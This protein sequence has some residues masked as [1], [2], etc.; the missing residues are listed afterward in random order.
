MKQVLITIHLLNAW[1]EPILFTVEYGKG[2]TFPHE[3]SLV[4]S[5]VLTNY[6]VYMILVD[7]GGVINI[8][9]NDVMTQTKIDPSR[10]IIVKTSLIR[11]VGTGMQVKGA[12]D[13]T[14]IIG[15]YSKYLTFQQ[16]LMIID[17]SLAYNVLL[18]LDA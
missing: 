17:T 7:D 8:L 6:H 16:N 9:S 12:L 5:I 18:A 10:L 2:V 15:T 3:N 1:H 13:I 4:I 14:V 11:I